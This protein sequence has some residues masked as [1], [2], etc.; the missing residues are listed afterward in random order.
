MPLL[1]R[2]LKLSHTEMKMVSGALKHKGRI[3]I[4]EMD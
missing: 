4:P 3:C 2:S 1:Q